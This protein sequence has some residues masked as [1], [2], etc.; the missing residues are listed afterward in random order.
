MIDGTATPT[1]KV[2]METP[3]VAVV[4]VWVV[5]EDEDAR[6]KTFTIALPVMESGLFTVPLTRVA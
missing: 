2:V 4:V 5:D 6:A 3:L 1:S